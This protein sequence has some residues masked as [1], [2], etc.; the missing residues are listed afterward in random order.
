M[1]VAGSKVSVNFNPAPYRR[2]QGFSGALVGRIAPC[3]YVTG[4]FARST[5]KGSTG[6]RVGIAF[7]L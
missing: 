7:G 2:Q 4:G 3:I 6:G 1:I 5:R